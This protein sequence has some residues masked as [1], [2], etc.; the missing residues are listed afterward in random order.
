[1]NYG[2]AFFTTNKSGFFQ[3]CEMVLHIYAMMEFYVLCSALA[4]FG[5]TSYLESQ[6]NDFYGREIRDFNP[7][8]PALLLAVLC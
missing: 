8:S 2:A 1:M 7:W 4:V 5:E 3:C 6:E